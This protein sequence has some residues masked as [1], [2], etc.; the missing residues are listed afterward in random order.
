MTLK[1]TH[2]G[3]D[4]ERHIYSN[5]TVKDFIGQMSVLSGIEVQKLKVENLEDYKSTRVD[6]LLYDK[7]T[8]KLP[9]EMR[10]LNTMKDAKV[11]HMNRIM[12]T[13]IADNEE[14]NFDKKPAAATANAEETEKLHDYTVIV[15][16]GD[17][18]DF[19]RYPISIDWTIEQLTDFLKK[20]LELGSQAYRLRNLTEGRM[21]HEEE[22]QT[23]LREYEDFHE[24][25]T[26]ITIELGRPTTLAEI[27]IDVIMYNKDA[28]VRQYYFNADITVKEARQIICLDFAGYE[29][30]TEIDP[31]KHTLYRGDAFNEPA[32][33]LRRLNG[34]FKNNNVASGELLILQ[35][36]K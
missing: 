9:V 31:N 11:A 4:Y 17:S 34:T 25:G 12:L 2:A 3:K 22:L 19:F 36:Q 30:N 29:G 33:V 32:Y 14:E 28:D 1:I 16:L 18:T 10:V 5:L 24:S 35:G 13:V 8:I 23:K 7:E 15:N 26:R 21:Y 6:R 27:T 20:E